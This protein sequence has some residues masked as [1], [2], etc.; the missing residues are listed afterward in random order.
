MGG[1]GSHQFTA[2]CE[3]GEDVIVYCEDGS[4]AAN[5]ERAGV[6]P[7]PPAEVRPLESLPPEQRELFADAQLDA[8][9]YADDPAARFVL[10]HMRTHRIGDRV[11][12]DGPVVEAITRDGAVLRSGAVRALVPHP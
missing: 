4:Y 12:T 1:S 6:D 9:V 10:I 5:L 3:T 7:L 11:G 2:P 8:H